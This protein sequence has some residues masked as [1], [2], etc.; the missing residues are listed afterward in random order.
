MLF[1]YLFLSKDYID[2]KPFRNNQTET[3]GQVHI[4]RNNV[5]NNEQGVTTSFS[6]S[7]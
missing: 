5:I 1:R 4:I 6:M 3:E 2:V 7:K